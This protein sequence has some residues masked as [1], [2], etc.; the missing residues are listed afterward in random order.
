MLIFTD[1]PSFPLSP[2]LPFYH[3]LQLNI[4]GDLQ[5]CSIECC[6]ALVYITVSFCIIS[7]PASLSSHF[8]RD[9]YQNLIRLM[10]PFHGVPRHINVLNHLVLLPSAP[11]I[12][13]SIT[14]LKKNQKFSLIRNMRKSP[15]CRLNSALLSVRFPDFAINPE[16]R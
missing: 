1:F 3:A 5:Y 13:V 10:S 14:W 8:Q 12:S 11:S 15:V 16:L 7:S 4:I 2:P 9:T 6:L